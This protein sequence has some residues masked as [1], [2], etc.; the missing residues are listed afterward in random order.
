MLAGISHLLKKS[1]SLNDYGCMGD[2]IQHTPTHECI[3]LPEYMGTSISSLVR[4]RD[5]ITTKHVIF[6]E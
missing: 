6:K 3:I 2:D 4:P 1:F 5:E